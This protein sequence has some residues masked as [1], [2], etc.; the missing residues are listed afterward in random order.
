MK[1]SLLALVKLVRMSVDASE[2]VHQPRVDAWLCSMPRCT[3]C[4]GSRLASCN[5]MFCKT[6]KP[7]LKNAND[8][9]SHVEDDIIDQLEVD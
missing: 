4:E 9:F 1:S 5:S 2:G 6:L 3:E 8:R 7:S